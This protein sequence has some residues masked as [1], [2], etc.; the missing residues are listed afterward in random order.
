MEIA[1]VASDF[2][3]VLVALVI[4]VFPRALEAFLASRRR[5]PNAD[6]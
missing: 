2:G 3:F 4:A 5:R 1:K 6:K